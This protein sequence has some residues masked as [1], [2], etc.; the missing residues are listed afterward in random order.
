MRTGWM[1]DAPKRALFGHR[2]PIFGV[3]SKRVANFLVATIAHG[4][5]EVLKDTVKGDCFETSSPGLPLGPAI[6][7]QHL[8]NIQN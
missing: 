8:W 7:N 6:V 3:S 1:Q 5:R 4:I 2:S